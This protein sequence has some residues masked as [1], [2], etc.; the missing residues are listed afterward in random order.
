MVGCLVAHIMDVA[1]AKGQGFAR[2]DLPAGEG[3][4]A[5][6]VTPRNGLDEGTPD[7]VERTARTAVVVQFGGGLAAMR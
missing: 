3:H 7:D 4:P 2:M 1:G 5:L 6:V